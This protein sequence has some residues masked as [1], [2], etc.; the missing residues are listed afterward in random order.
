MKKLYKFYWY[1]GRQG[2]LEGLFIAD[3]SEVGNAMGKLVDFG[4]ALGKHSDIRGHLEEED[5]KEIKVS[6]ITLKEMEEVIGQ[7]ISGY[8]PLNYI[9]YTC[10]KCGDSGRVDEMDWYEDKYGNKICEYCNK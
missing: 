9:R 10:N 1:C 3:D 2:E 4:E 6:E 8:N 7:T 5:L